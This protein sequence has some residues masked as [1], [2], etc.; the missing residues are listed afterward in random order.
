MLK[1]HGS[2]KANAGPGLGWGVLEAACICRSGVKPRQA[3]VHPNQ[4]VITRA[5]TLKLRGIPT[6]I[7]SVK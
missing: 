5:Y 7:P 6:S 1:S 3:G 4:T 2:A